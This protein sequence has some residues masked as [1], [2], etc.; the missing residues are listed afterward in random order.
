MFTRWFD[1][2]KWGLEKHLQG[3]LSPRKAPKIRSFG[4]EI[5]RWWRGWDAGKLK[6]SINSSWDPCYILHLEEPKKTTGIFWSFFSSQGL[7]LFVFCLKKSC[8]VEGQKLGISLDVSFSFGSSDSN[9]K[10]KREIHEAYTWNIIMVI[11][12]M[13]GSG[14]PQPITNSF[15]CFARNFLGFDWDRCY[16][17][18]NWFIYIC[19]YVHKNDLQ[20]WNIISKTQN[21]WQACNLNIVSWYPN[22]PWFLGV[23][24]MDAFMETSFS[25]LLSLCFFRLPAMLES[26]ECRFGVQAATFSSDVFPSLLNPKSLPITCNKCTNKKQFLPPKTAA[27]CWAKAPPFLC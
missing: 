10:L 6:S 23:L 9:M 17:T 22:F 12:G 26:S 19:R 20:G 2:S 21:G 5:T 15:F 27:N 18:R 11:F 3:I 14:G 4:S 1:L 25:N 8:W 16:T 7:Y 24:G 13:L